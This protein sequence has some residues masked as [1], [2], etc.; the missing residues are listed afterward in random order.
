[1]AIE[2]RFL[3][4]GEVFYWTFFTWGFDKKWNYAVKFTPLEIV[5]HCGDNNTVIC[6]GL[7][8]NAVREFNWYWAYRIS[9]F[10]SMNWIEKRIFFISLNLWKFNNDWVFYFYFVLCYSAFIAEIANIQCEFA[11]GLSVEEC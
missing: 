11:Q 4:R 7:Y 8:A 2:F 3:F 9:E 6:N 10:N 5:S 1:M